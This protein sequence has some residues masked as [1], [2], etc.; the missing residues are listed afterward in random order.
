MESPKTSLAEAEMIAAILAGA[1]QLYQ[2]LI[3]PH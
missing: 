1:T 3:R 2:E